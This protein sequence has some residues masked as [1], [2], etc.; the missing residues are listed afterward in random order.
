MNTQKSDQK[1]DADEE[2]FFSAHRVHGRDPSLFSLWELFNAAPSR[3][4]KAKT[5]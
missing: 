5:K 1:Y 3:R 2:F 4:K